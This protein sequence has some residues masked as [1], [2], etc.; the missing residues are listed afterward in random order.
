M[1]RLFLVLISCIVLS[2]IVYFGI[3]TWKQIDRSSVA[4]LSADAASKIKS[5]LHKPAAKKIATPSKPTDRATLAKGKVI[6]QILAQ[7]GFTGTVVAVSNNKIVLNK[8]YG[9]SDLRTHTPNTLHTRYYIGSMT[10]A[11]TAVAF[12]QLREQHLIDFTDHVSDFYP[13]FPNGRRITMIDL[14]DHVSGLG[15]DRESMTNLTRDQLVAKIAKLNPRLHSVPGTSWSYEDT[16]YALLGAILD[17][18]CAAHFSENLHEYCLHSIF[19]PADMTQSGFGIAGEQ[20]LNRSIPYFL[21]GKLIIEAYAPSFSQLLGCGDVYATAWD[22]YLFDHALASGRLLS[23]ESM[24]EL[25]RSRYPGTSYSMGWYLSRNGWGEDTNSS[26]GVLGGWN[27]SNAFTK[28]G[29]NYLILLSNFNNPHIHY[30]VLNKKIFTVLS[31]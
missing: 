31:K 13:A 1:R 22:M 15:G 28:D 16:N 23:S 24:H 3:L 5:S 20:S 27:G 11:I 19:A 7:S 26:H 6:N 4:P 10:K 25:F 29:R 14:L 8:S 12:L 17:K 30:D 2:G 21:S 18:I 9:H